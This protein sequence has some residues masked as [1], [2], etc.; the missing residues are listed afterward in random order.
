[1]GQR[2]QKPFDDPSLVVSGDVDRHERVITKVDVIAVLQSGAMLAVSIPTAV[3]V[4]TVSTERQRREQHDEGAQVVLDRI[5]KEHGAEEETRERETVAEPVG[6]ALDL[7]LSDEV[8]KAA[9]ERDDRRD[10]QDHGRHQDSVEQSSPEQKAAVGSLTKPEDLA[11]EQ[12]EPGQGQHRRHAITGHR[13]E[14]IENYDPDGGGEQHERAP[15]AHRSPAH[16]F[17]LS[18]TRLHRSP[19]RRRRARFRLNAAR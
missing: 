15:K 14:E 12:D 7:R 11:S 1:M 16:G 2:D 17:A 9:D 19:H 18:V 13:L 5:G 10:R 6:T 8:G 3:A 4:A